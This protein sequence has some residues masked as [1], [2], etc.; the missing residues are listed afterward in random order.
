[1]E[2]AWPRGVAR[3]GKEQ[4]DLTC[5]GDG[6]WLHF[7]ASNSQKDVLEIK[8]KTTLISLKWNVHKNKKKEI[9]VSLLCDCTEHEVYLLNLLQNK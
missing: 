4:S 7:T 9:L 8:S 2:L 5:S 1:M 3:E 6:E